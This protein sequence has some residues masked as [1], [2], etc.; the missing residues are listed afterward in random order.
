MSG[1]SIRNEIE[2][3]N[4]PKVQNMAA[5]FHKYM[6]LMQYLHSA[7]IGRT[8]QEICAHLEVSDSTSRK[9]IRALKDYFEIPDDEF[10]ET[11]EKRFRILG[12]RWRLRD[13]EQD[14]HVLGLA[15]ELFRKEGQIEQSVRLRALQNQMTGTLKPNEQIRIAPDLELLGQEEGWAMRPGPRSELNADRLTELRQALLGRKK[16]KVN[17]KRRR[18]NVVETVIIEPHGILFG[19]R[20]YLVAFANGE[21]AKMPRLFV[22]ANL[23]AIQ[24]LNEHFETRSGFDFKDYVAKSFGVWHGDGNFDVVWR[25]PQ[26]SAVDVMNY[27][28]HPTEKKV[29]LPDG[30][31]EVQFTADGLHE[32]A[33]HLFTWEDPSTGR[34]V[35]I[36]KPE[37]LRDTY[38][39][40]LHHALESLDRA[41]SL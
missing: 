15:A 23:E 27:H 37:K 9:M 14:I 33:F 28:F 40:M 39:Q 21:T 22:I 34:S 13:F 20:N 1:S 4:R 2:L 12:I 11:G 31:V 19:V 7:H 29:S 41:R 6:E 5:I 24:V 10:S 16:L 25:F 32:M 18:D 38:R 36:V 30:R 3:S 8:Y 17:Y 35:E 26:I